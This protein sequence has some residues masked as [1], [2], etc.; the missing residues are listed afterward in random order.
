M[1]CEILEAIPI[2]KSMNSP[3]LL[4]D[5]CS[6][7]DL[8]RAPFRSN[9]KLSHIFGARKA[10]EELRC[11]KLCC[12]LTSTVENELNDHLKDTGIELE[13][14]VR[15]IEIDITK[16]IEVMENLDI[17]FDLNVQGLSQARIPE[18]LNALTNEFLKEAIILDRDKECGERAH[19]RVERNQAPSKRGKSESKDC[20]IIEHYLKLVNELRNEGFAQ[21]IVFLTSNYQDFGQPPTPLAPIDNQFKKLSILYCNNFAW[22]LN[23]CGINNQNPLA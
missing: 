16:I 14:H 2:I 11:Q 22:A 5:T 19:T 8:I 10:L 3:V 12:V 4:M 9:I 1:N 21:K 17:R 7:V 20:L 13:R 6:L 23:Q 15:K 18:H